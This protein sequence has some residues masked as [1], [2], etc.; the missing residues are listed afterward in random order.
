M[1]AVMGGRAD[2]VTGVH[3]SNGVVVGTFPGTNLV[4]GLG[5]HGIAGG[6]FNVS[7][8]LPISA[9]PADLTGRIGFEYGN[10]VTVH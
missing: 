1:F 2:Y 10:T 7:A 3:V 9:A 4:A 6:G 5:L 8:T